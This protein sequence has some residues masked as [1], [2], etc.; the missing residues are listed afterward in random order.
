MQKQKS[1]QNLNDMES[2][3]L[4]IVICYKTIFFFLFLFC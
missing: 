1:K 4:N 3:D 2:D